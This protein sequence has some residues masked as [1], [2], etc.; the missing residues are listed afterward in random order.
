[1]GGL[2]LS[3]TQ[4]EPRTVQPTAPHSRPQKSGRQLDLPT[5]PSRPRPTCLVAPLFL[6]LA[7]LV[8]LEAPGG[9]NQA[10]CAQHTAFYPGF[11]PQHPSIPS[12]RPSSDLS[13]PTISQ[14]APSGAPWEMAL[15]CVGPPMP[16]PQ[17]CLNM[18]G[19]LLICRRLTHHIWL[20]D[21]HLIARLVIVL[22][23]ST[24]ARLPVPS[25]WLVVGPRF[26]T[27]RRWFTSR[28]PG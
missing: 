19:K 14:D 15:G 10:Q 13:R 18:P 11:S 22:V 12:A 28:D 27:L 23:L 25:P 3:E 9:Q 1:M 4:T 24:D 16:P 6:D 5:S 20:A 8:S 21:M 7:S 17:L 2:Y 26:A